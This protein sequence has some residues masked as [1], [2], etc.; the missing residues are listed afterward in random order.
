MSHRLVALVLAG[1]FLTSAASAAWAHCVGWSSSVA[2][3]HACCRGGAMAPEA[4]ATACCAMSQQSDE[5]GPVEARVA[6]APVK[7]VR[8]APQ[9]VAL[10][11]PGPAPAFHAPVAVPAFDS[12]PLY[13]RQSALLI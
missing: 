7:M 10:V 2:D 3:R 6:A 5:S 1:L 12:V 9:P 4:R 13:L 8:H 11:V